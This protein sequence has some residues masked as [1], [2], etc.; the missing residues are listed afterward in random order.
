MN[1]GAWRLILPLSIFLVSVSLSRAEID[2]PKVSEAVNSVDALQNDHLLA[3]EVDREIT[4][5][6]KSKPNFRTVV[7]D[8]T[9][10]EDLDTAD[11]QS[12]TTGD[13]DETDSEIGLDEDDTSIHK[14][15]ADKDGE[16]T[17]DIADRQDHSQDAI[18]D[19]AAEMDSPDIFGEANILNVARLDVEAADEAIRNLGDIGDED[20]NEA[21]KEDRD[22]EVALR[23]LEMDADVVT[24]WKRNE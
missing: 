13:V 22:I 11:R 18:L 15:A 24:G 4:A 12:V 9:A 17:L 6:D 14:L 1:Q 8:T 7:G 23:E 10:H 5:F 2:T 21:Q 20:D 19:T 16:K 3:A